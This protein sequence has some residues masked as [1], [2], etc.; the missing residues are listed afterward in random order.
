MP[1][2]ITYIAVLVRIVRNFHKPSQY[3]CCSGLEHDIAL[4][5]TRN[6][7]L[8]AQSKLNFVLQIRR[9]MLTL[10]GKL[11]EKYVSASGKQAGGSYVCRLSLNPNN[12]KWHQENALHHATTIV[13]IKCDSAWKTVKCNTRNKVKVK[14]LES[15]KS[16]KR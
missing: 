3:V 7:T 4:D 8:C 12:W 2:L 10:R 13:Q 11:A 15:G 6:L 16:L 1:T 9:D 5:S 14:C